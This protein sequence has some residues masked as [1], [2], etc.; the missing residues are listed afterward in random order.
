MR[1]LTLAWRLN[2]V[3]WGEW[4]EERANSESR[5]VGGGDPG[6]PGR[7]YWDKHLW[8][9]SECTGWGTSLWC[10][11]YGGIHQARRAGVFQ[12][13]A[14]DV[15]GAAGTHRAMEDGGHGGHR[16]SEVQGPAQSPGDA[17]TKSRHIGWQVTEGRNGADCGFSFLPNKGLV[18][19]NSPD[20][21][22][23]KRSTEPCGDG[24]HAYTESLEEL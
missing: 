13:K 19:L 24:P 9:R 16:E 22:L 17:N 21:H 7:S 6:G 2:T 15:M 5:M 4:G 8:K 12:S 11:V 20:V 14:T 10:M 1:Q 18:S 23:Q 3:V